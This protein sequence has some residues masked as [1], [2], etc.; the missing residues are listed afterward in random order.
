MTR[1]AVQEFRR[2][3]LANSRPVA[4]KF[5]MNYLAHGYRFL[6]SPL[7]LAGT[8]LPDCLS[9]VDRRVRLRGRR[10]RELLDQLSAEEREVAEGVLQHLRDDD[11]FHA[12]PTFLMLESELT[13]RFRRVLT[14]RFD[15]RPPFLGHIVTELLLDAVIAEEHPGVLEGWYRSMESVSGEWI[16]TVVNRLA[17]Q[18]TLGLPTFLGKFLN[19]RVLFDYLDDER[20]LVRLN[21]VLRRVTLPE[22]DGECLS[23]LSTARLLLRKHARA[24]LQAVERA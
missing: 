1:L 10:I 5:A 20:L 8:A 11:L 19:A 2:F 14:D 9:V 24:L 4:V 7:R 12:C 13:G 3:L 17:T 23:V 16:Q 15:H 22:I 21:Q 18:S 6:E